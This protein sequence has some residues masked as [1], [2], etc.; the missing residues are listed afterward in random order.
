MYISHADNEWSNEYTDKNPNRKQLLLIKLIETK[1]YDK[2]FE[3]AYYNY[4][5]LKGN[6]YFVANARPI[7]M[8]NKEKAVVYDIVFVDTFH[9]MT[10]GP[11]F[12][13]HYTAAV[14]HISTKAARAIVEY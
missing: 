14:E 13:N 11:H 1:L 8:F 2:L 9:Y 7:Q 3:Y 4:E 12:P 10:S 6:L 5:G